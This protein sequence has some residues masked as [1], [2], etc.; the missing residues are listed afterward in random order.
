MATSDGI[1]TEDWDKVHQH[2]VDLFNAD[3]EEKEESR[4][5]LF[6]CL[7]GLHRKYGPLPSILA[8]RGDFTEDLVS[9]EL[10]LL[11]AYDLARQKDDV[12]NRLHISH[13]LAD[14]YV[15]DRRDIREGL[16]WI[17]VLRRHLATTCDAHYSD[18]V[19]RLT[20]AL[21]EVGD[22]QARS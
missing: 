16:A 13:S 3:D 22:R 17:A 2:A 18:E 10:L 15:D 20:K 12:S 21:A 11:E 6:V 4:N 14:L 9:K 19:E 8:T 5:Q 1:S 7:D